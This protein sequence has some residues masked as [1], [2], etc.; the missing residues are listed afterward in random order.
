MLYAN[1]ATPNLEDR[2]GRQAFLVSSGN[3]PCA[4]CGEVAEAVDDSPNIP[5]ALCLRCAEC[6][7]ADPG[8]KPDLPYEEIRKKKSGMALRSEAARLMAEAWVQHRQDESNR[9][10]ATLV[11]LAENLRMMPEEERLAAELLARLLDAPLSTVAMRDANTGTSVHDFDLICEDGRRIAVEVT[12]DGTEAV[13]A[14]LAGLDKQ[15]Q[16]WDCPQTSRSWMVAVDPPG[17][18][19]RGEGSLAWPL[20]DEL[21][22]ELPDILVQ[23]EQLVGPADIDY[24][25]VRSPVI[26][27]SQPL[28][29]L[30]SALQARGVKHATALPVH[31]GPTCIYA[32]ISSILGIPNPAAIADAAHRHAV[33]RT[34][35]RKKLAAAKTGPDSAHEAHLLIWV[36][37]LDKFRAAFFAIVDS[38]DPAEVPIPAGFKEVLGSIDVVWVTTLNFYR[39]DGRACRTVYR[40]DRNGWTAFTDTIPYTTAGR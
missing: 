33:E 17:S 38:V 4:L 10:A 26:D 34:D 16:A 2:A 30:K 1:A 9:G 5:L 18:G 7:E 12:T 13:S 8:W 29:E 25:D 21:K 37:S 20:I 22:A 28:R 32:N 36:P 3:V 27:D 35:N 11:D 39:K 31:E 24:F 15:G 40:L 19:A 14:F 6:R 23:V